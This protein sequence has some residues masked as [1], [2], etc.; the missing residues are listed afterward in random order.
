M[1]E[2]KINSE[3][4]SLQL[5]QLEMLKIVHDICV[6]NNIRYSLYAGTLLGAV[7][8]KGFIPWDDDLDIC[9]SRDDYNRF[10]AL[11][12]S[13]KP[14][15]YILQ[16]KENSPGF[17][18]SFTKIRKDHTTFLQSNEER[19]KYHVGIF[20][21]IFPIDRIPDG[22]LN[23]IFFLWN[24][25]RYQLYMRGFVPPKGNL[26]EKIVATILL[27]CVS[28]GKRYKECNLL[29]NRITRFNK[30]SNFSTVAIE[31][32]QSMR[33]PLPSSLMEQFVYLPFESGEYMCSKE[34][35]AFLQKKYDDYMVLPPENERVWKHHPLIVD[36]THN[37]EELG[38]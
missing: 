2:D 23:R 7:R 11:W 8:H 5:V 36:F 33:Q 30:N 1:E 12:P 32:F 34:W 38:E 37:L 13:E 14:E 4:R 10:I 17:T 26:V 6:K 21:D 9:M 15:G 35:D 29:L 31:T 22:K 25:L 3:L 27:K 20:I 16:N 18:Q 19:G 24:C 28:E